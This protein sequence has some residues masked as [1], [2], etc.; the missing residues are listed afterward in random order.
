MSLYVL[1]DLHLSF[2]TDKPMNIFK[3]WGNH[4]EKITA[5][6]NA[7][8]N[9]E[10]TVVINGDISWATYLRDAEKDFRYINDN[11]KGKKIFLKGNHDYWW[12]TKSKLDAFLQEKA[13]DKIRILNNNSYLEAGIAVCGTR[14]W[15]NDGSEPF[16]QKLLNREAGRLDMSISDAKRLGGEPVVFI[17]Y[18]PIFGNEKNYYIIDVLKKH[19]VK[20]CYYGHVHGPAVKQAFTGESD[21]INYHIASCDCVNFTPVLVKE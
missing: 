17:H 13:L 3:G 4:V 2:S 8:V 18:P 10:D 14:G 15:I 21:G 12:T 11:L 9:E 6:W 5:N 16:D 7:L 1:G 19:G 20:D